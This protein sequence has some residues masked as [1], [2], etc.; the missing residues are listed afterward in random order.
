MLRV[1]QRDDSLNALATEGTT[2]HP[3]EFRTRDLEIFGSQH[4]PPPW[5]EV[6]QLVERLCEHV[7]EGDHDPLDVAAYV[8][9]RLNW[10]H[11]FEEGNGRTA[12]AVSYLVL[13]AFACQALPGERTAVEML[14]WQKQAYYRALEAADEAWRDGRLDVSALRTLLE[15]L[16]KKQL[17]GD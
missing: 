14:G 8:L 1:A 9:W 15:A 13:C 10:V 16:V 5:Q 7:N 4:A 11:P 3:G 6:K 17:D 12:R 2:D